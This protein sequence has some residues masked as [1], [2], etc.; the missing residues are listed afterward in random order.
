MH[1]MDKILIIVLSSNLILAS[2]KNE[3]GPRLFLY[4]SI[5]VIQ[6]FS[7]LSEILK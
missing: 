4:I 3:D 6:I 5:L 7:I 2:L 1:I